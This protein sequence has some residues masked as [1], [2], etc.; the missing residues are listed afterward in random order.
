MNQTVVALLLFCLII[1]CAYISSLC[2]EDVKNYIDC[3]N[4]VQE[5]QQL[6]V[7]SELKKQ[8]SQEV[9]C[10]TKYKYRKRYNFPIKDYLF[11]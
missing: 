10:F 6:D 2:T 7:E 8:R 4:N 11:L 9:E 1:K 5:K 3:V